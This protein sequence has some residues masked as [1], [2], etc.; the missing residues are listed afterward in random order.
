VQHIDDI[1]TV[2]S[3]TKQHK[4]KG[5]GPNEKGAQ[6]PVVSQKNSLPKYNVQTIA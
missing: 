5:K 4:Q 3:T 1:E 6:S 2:I